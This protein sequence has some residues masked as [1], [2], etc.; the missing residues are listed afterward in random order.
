MLVMLDP[1]LPDDIEEDIFLTDED[2]DDV[3][4]S[5]LLDV[6][7]SALFMAG[8]LFRGLELWRL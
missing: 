2:D 7:L 5:S 1:P 4:R 6:Y 8:K 3:F